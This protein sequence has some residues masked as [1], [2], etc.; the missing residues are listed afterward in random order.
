MENQ[1]SFDND[2]VVKCNDC[3][4]V[5]LHHFRTE[6]YNRASE[7]TPFGTLSVVDDAPPENLMNVKHQA[8]FSNNPSPR[9]N[10]IRI[11]FYCECCPKVSVLDIIQH[12]GSTYIEWE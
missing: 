8:A 12:K 6:V 2:F 10:G 4:G 3:G 5:C 7:D 1:V 11:F 9:R